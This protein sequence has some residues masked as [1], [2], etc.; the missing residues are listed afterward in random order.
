MTSGLHSHPELPDG[1]EPP[2]RPPEPERSPLAAVPVWAPLAGLLMAFVAAA[3]A[4]VLIGAAIEAGGGSI[5]EGD[6]PPGLLIGATFVQDAALIAAAAF[7]AR[8]WSSGVTPATF[9]LRPGQARARDRLDAARLGSL[10]RCQPPLLHA[11]RA[12]RGP[13]AHARPQ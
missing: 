3:I 1:I 9:G 2:Q 13:G 11:R 5:T 10:P 8:I 4:A 7:L 12:A 6:T